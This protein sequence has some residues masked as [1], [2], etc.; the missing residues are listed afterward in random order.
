[1]APPTRRRRALASP[2]RRLSPFACRGSR[3]PI[4]LVVAEPLDGGDAQQQQ[5]L[6]N[7]LRA[8][9][10]GLIAPDRERRAVFCPL[11]GASGGEQAAL[12]GAI[13]TVA[14]RCI[15]AFGRAGAPPRCS[16][17]TSRSAACAVASTPPPACR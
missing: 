7:M 13:A 11:A 16:A 5:L 4:W 14:P 17:T 3:R 10:V 6:E 1:M 12:Q 15:L 9:G 2:S 8:I